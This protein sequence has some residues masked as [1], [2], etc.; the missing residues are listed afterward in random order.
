MK[1]DKKPQKSKEFVL[2]LDEI[3]TII[4]WLDEHNKPLE[5]F[6]FISLT[7]GGFRASELVH[8]QKDWLHIDDIYSQQL[9]VNHIQ[10]PGKGQYCDCYDCKLQ[11]FLETEQK[12]EG[13]IFT[14]E[15]YNKIRKDFDYDEFK[16][17]RYWEPK[18]VA[19][20]R[21]IPI[22]YDVFKNELVKF[23]SNK[24]Q[25]NYSRQW[26]WGVISD[27]SKDIWGYKTVFDVKTSKNRIILNKRLYP[28]ALR[29]TAASLW[30]FKGINA[31][32]LKS[33]MGWNSIDIADIYVKSDEKQA[34][35]MAKRIADSEK[36]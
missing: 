20:E 28:H 33:I 11:T 9:G 34:L 36:I 32:G 1:I 13:V 15:W 30:A 18:T 8:M 17:G 7:Y 27:I 22:V 21:K 12:K 26:V 25:L 19:G 35:L 6:V 24:N 4:K 16:E 2:K 23:Y 31:A 10:I 29:A 5:R 14:K 3:E